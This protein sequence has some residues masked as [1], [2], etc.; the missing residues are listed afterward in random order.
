M[1]YGL[2]ND[3]T[4]QSNRK[5]AEPTLN[6]SDFI[7]DA[8]DA[9][10]A[11]EL[12]SALAAEKTD[13]RLRFEWRDLVSLAGYEGKAYLIDT[14]TNLWSLKDGVLSVHSIGYLGYGNDGYVLDLV[15]EKE[16][17]I[18]HKDYFDAFLSDDYIADL[19]EKYGID[20]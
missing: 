2:I 19:C 12:L 16:L 17:Y 20:P 8:N 11:S 14:E 9:Q 5:H 7:W 6:I 4:T 15:Q 1:I 10:A 18:E 13:E 3:I